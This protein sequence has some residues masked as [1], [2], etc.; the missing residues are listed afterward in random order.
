MKLLDA[1]VAFYAVGTAHRY[2][3]PCIKLL[4]Q[5]ARS[6]FAFAVDTELLQEVLYVYSYRGEKD[7]GLSVFDDL[8]TV[9]PSPLSIGPAE[10]VVARRIFADFPELSPRDA[11]HAAVVETYQLEGIVTTDRAFLQIPHLTVFDPIALASETP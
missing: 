9:F 1:N 4:T 10:M 7:R 5:A 11:I 2:K 6:S 8:L 3:D